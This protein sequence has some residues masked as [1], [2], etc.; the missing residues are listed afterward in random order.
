MDR[1][2]F[3]CGENRVCLL[4]LSRSHSQSQEEKAYE[5]AEDVDG[6]EEEYYEEIITEQEGLWAV[7][8]TQKRYGRTPSEPTPN[9]LNCLAAG[10]SK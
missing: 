5:A 10:H 7:F 4:S 3:A 9:Q 6:E 1:R 2:P 8:Q